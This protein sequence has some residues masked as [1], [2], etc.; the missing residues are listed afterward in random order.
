MKLWK[1]VFQM[2]IPW[3]IIIPTAGSIIGGLLGGKG[4]NQADTDGGRRYGEL[5][6]PMSAFIRSR[7]GQGTPKY[8][9]ET[10]SIGAS[11]ESNIARALRGETSENFENMFRTLYREPAAELL[12][13]E[14]LPGV[15]QS[16][17]GP[18]TYWGSERAGAES[19][20]IRDSATKLGMSRERVAEADIGRALQYSPSILQAEY[21]KFLDALPEYSPLIQAALGLLQQSPYK[22]PAAQQPSALPDI[23]ASLVEMYQAYQQG[24]VPTTAK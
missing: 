19:K 17:V 1:E 13:E 18:G 22:Q 21:Q 4:K 23:L 2:P 15:R 12:Q 9:P 6:D 11:A 14:V 10:G 8:K 16:Y 5:F 24:K 3:N 7:I 20:A